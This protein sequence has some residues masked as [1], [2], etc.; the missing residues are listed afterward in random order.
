MWRVLKL[1]PVALRYLINVGPL[2]YEAVRF[3]IKVVKEIRPQ[4][5]K[6]KG[7][8]DTEVPAENADP[9]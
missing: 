9:G 8:S 5:K 6:P 7:G 2:L 1:I 4:K 3:G